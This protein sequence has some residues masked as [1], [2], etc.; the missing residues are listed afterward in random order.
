MLYYIFF[1][2]SIFIHL[3]IS[4]LF[5]HQDCCMLC[6]EMVEAKI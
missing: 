6:G 3:L 2:I 4:P 5:G 1:D